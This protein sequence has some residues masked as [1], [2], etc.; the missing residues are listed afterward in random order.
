MQIACP[1]NSESI[2]LS[3]GSI[4]SYLYFQEKPICKI[5][6]MHLSQRIVVRHVDPHRLH[7]CLEMAL[8]APYLSL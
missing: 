5:R 3:R 8:F 2:H 7:L 6:K 4:T 1:L